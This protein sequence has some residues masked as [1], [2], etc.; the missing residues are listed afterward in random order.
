MD[1]EEKI[2]P[3][4]LALE[5]EPGTYKLNLVSRELHDQVGGSI[6]ASLNFLEMHELDWLNNDKQARARISD[7][8]RMMLRALSATRQLAAYARMPTL[9]YAPLALGC[10]AETG[11]EEEPAPSLP[12]LRDRS[13]D[14]IDQQE[15]FFILREAVRNAIAHSRAESVTVRLSAR[16]S[17]LAVSVEDDGAGI[18]RT[19]AE[20]PA[21]LGLRSMRERAALLGGTFELTCGPSGGTQ[22]VVTFP[23]SQVKE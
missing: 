2:G 11:A 19:L 15:I 18:Q 13:A 4:G 20:S 3:D 1:A 9:P 8:R 12:A 7:A 21:S 14:Q 23:L 5:H 10:I 22:V 16:D 6:A 17:E